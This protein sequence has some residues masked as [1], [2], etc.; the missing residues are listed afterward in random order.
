[1][2]RKSRT[3]PGLYYLEERQ[4]PD[5]PGLTEM[6]YITKSGWLVYLFDRRD[7]HNGSTVSLDHPESEKRRQF[8]EHDLALRGPI[9][10]YGAWV[11]EV[12]AFEKGDQVGWKDDI[13]TDA[14]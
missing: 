9:E 5:E 14:S 12:I 1:M 8:T 13:P 10:L 3:P 2:P 6:V 11:E 7:G 4:F